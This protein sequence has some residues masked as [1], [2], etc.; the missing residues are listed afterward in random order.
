MT[1]AF[2][3]YAGMNRR[4]E[5]GQ[6]DSHRVPRVCGDEPR[7]V[8]GTGDVGRAFPAYAGMNRSALVTSPLAARVPRVCGDEPQAEIMRENMERRSPRMRG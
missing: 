6:Q 2:P 3:A 7:P 1:E 4:S 5:S 8:P